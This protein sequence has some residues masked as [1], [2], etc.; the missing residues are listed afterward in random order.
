[1]ARSVAMMVGPAE[2]SLPET[3][4]AAFTTGRWTRACLVFKGFVRRA[5]SG[6]AGALVASGGAAAMAGGGLVGSLVVVATGLTGTGAGGSRS[7]ISRTTTTN[8]AITNTASASCKR[9]R[10]SS[11]G[12]AGAP[13]VRAWKNFSRVLISKPTAARLIA[14]VCLKI[15]GKASVYAQGQRF[16]RQVTTGCG[17]RHS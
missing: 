12:P 10:C 5:V 17:K 9:R 4:C 1:M 3:D 13:A 14:I 16:V 15:A 8:S 2:S 11:S 7:R 6:R